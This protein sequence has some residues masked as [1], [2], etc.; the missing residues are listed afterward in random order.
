MRMGVSGR[1]LKMLLAEAGAERRAP[2]GLAPEPKPADSFS[3]RGWASVVDGIGGKEFEQIGIGRGLL[4][5]G[6][7]ARDD[8][9]A[10]VAK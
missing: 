9:A 7:M 2:P 3:D 8:E 1:W 5:R 6:E 10:V 4:G